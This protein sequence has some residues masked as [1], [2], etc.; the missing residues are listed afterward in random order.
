MAVKPMRDRIGTLNRIIP[1]RQAELREVQARSAEYLA[2]RRESEDVQKRMA[3]QDPDFQLLPFLESLTERQNLNAHVATM[4]QTDAPPSRSGYSETVVEIGLEGVRLSQLA[5]LLGA[6]EESS[7]AVAQI[8]SL[9]IRKQ[10]QDAMRLD[11]TI[12]IYSPRTTLETVAAEA[13]LR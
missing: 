2:L 3:E 7:E 1:D 4:Q 13:T 6:V 11:A 8:G 12:R 9:H 10:S 5:N